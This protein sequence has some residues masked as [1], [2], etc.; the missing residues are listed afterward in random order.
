MLF[1]LHNR[2]TDDTNKNSYK[3]NANKEG[4]MRNLYK[5]AYVCSKVL[6]VFVWIILVGVLFFLAVCGFSGNSIIE[7]IAAGTL[8]FNS[9]NFGGLQLRIQNSDITVTVLIFMGIA[10]IAVAICMIFICRQINIMFRSV[11]R[12]NT[13][14]T[15]ENII[16]IKSM[17]MVLIVYNLFDFILGFLMKAAVQNGNIIISFSLNGLMT[18]LLL[19][20]LS[21]IFS[22]G[23]KLQQEVDETL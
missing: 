19:I 15:K 3:V 22:Y 5:A 1:C 4:Y 16:R 14:F 12:G 21:G 2:G 17:G 13:P 11:Y 8:G 20:C 10:I 6:E 7:K 9:T 23:I 18:G